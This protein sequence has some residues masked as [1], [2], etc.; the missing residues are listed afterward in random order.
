ME[1]RL[2]CNLFPSY[3]IA[4]AFC[5][6]SNSTIVVSCKKYCNGH[7]VRIK[8]GAKLNS[9]RIL[10]LWE[11]SL[12]KR[13]LCR[14]RL[15][16]SSLAHSPTSC[17]PHVTMISTLYVSTKNAGVHFEV[18]GGGGGGCFLVWYPNGFVFFFYNFGIRIGHACRFWKWYTTYI[19]TTYFFR[20]IRKTGK[21]LFF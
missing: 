11:I 6:C 18:A 14:H 16:H 20:K 17:L 3:H 1:N 9:H 13:A 19:M 8:M 2:C 7:S 4:A 21:F 12:V 15:F 10:I 5:A